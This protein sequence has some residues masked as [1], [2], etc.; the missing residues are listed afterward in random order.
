MTLGQL[1]KGFTYNDVILHGGSQNHVYVS[2]VH[3]NTSIVSRTHWMQ[4]IRLR[5]PFLYTHVPTM[6][7]SESVIS[8]ARIGGM[9]VVSQTD[10][11]L[12][13]AQEVKRIKSIPILR[14]GS[15]IALGSPIV[16]AMVGVDVDVQE[17]IYRLLSAGV[18]AVVVQNE[19]RFE[20][21]FETMAMIR[22]ISRF[23]PIIAGSVHSVEAAEELAHAGANA[24]IIDAT[25]PRIT[26]IMNI[27][28]ALK[29]RNISLITYGGQT[30]AEDITKTL[31]AGASALFCEA[32]LDVLH[33][34]VTGLRSYLKFFRCRTIGELRTA[35]HFTRPTSS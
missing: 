25:E 32:R 15:P 1:K 23:I 18:D 6:R 7:E 34:C 11:P 22:R 28:E 31:A 8:L 4:G 26:N 27:S 2:E 10:S 21:M 9:N 16:A 33:R 19:S 24:I 3:T 5:V 13:Q 14:L 30:S 12:E 29:G 17:R 20:P 35:V